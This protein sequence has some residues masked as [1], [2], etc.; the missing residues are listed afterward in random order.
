MKIIVGGIIEKNGKYLLVQEAQKKCYK[1]WNIPAGHLDFN[2]SLKNGG[3]REIKEETG[4]DVEL[5]GVCYIAN[6]IL[7]D[8]LFVMICFNAK[9]IN[10]NI[11]FDK[12]EILDV[13]WFDYDEIQNNMDDMLRGTYVKNAIYNQNNNIIAPIEMVDIIKQK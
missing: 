9:L 10:E 11:K 13:K 12:E 2:E 3:I 5:T 7:E 8:D 4:C 1:K 6:R